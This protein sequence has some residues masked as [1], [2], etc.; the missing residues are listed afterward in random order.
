MS[1]NAEIRTRYGP[2][3]DKFSPLPRPTG[4][5]NGYKP[6]SQAAEN[7]TCAECQGKGCAVECMLCNGDSVNPGKIE[8]CVSYCS[9]ECRV[10][11]RSAHVESCY[12]RKRFARAV[13]FF[14]DIWA[15][16]QRETYH[17]NPVKYYS[18]QDN[19][20][21]DLALDD[22]IPDSRGWRGEFYTL[23]CLI[24][25]PLTCRKRARHW[26]DTS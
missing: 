2:F 19:G 26:F 21:I 18:E 10:R 23:C 13:D 4:D 25:S 15:A 1:G 6:P 20:Y 5:Q 14:A 17:L 8:I 11:H 24:T 12:N 7:R 3:G 16:Y 9:H 22:T